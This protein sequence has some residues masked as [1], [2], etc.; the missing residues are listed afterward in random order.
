VLAAAPGRSAP[1]GVAAVLAAI[2]SACGAAGG[3]GVGAGLSMAEAIA[4]SQR[5]TALVVGG[6]LGGGLVGTGVQWLGRWGLAA[7]VG[8]HVEIGGALE[9]LVIGGAAGLGYAA[10]TSRVAGG[11]AAPRGHR[12]VRV[13]AVAAEACALA[14]LA[15]TLAG[16]PLVGGTLHT[17][18]QAANGSQVSMTPLG[19]IVGEPDFGPISR[20]VIGMGEGGLFGFGLALGLTRRP[21][22]T[23]HAML[24]ER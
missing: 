7:L 11:I 20:A 3:A 8:V 4:R 12:R 19:R 9:G 24:T 18:A 5:T 14:G 1:I 15:L 23:S 17:I 10:A 16:R 22:S 21:S 6:A 2:G 13:A